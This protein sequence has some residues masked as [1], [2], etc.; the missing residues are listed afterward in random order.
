[1]PSRAQLSAEAV[2]PNG[3]NVDFL[4]ERVNGW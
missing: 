1:V 2:I 3:G 4:Q